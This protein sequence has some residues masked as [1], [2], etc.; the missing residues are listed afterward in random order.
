[1]KMFEISSNLEQKVN[2]FYNQNTDKAVLKEKAIENIVEDKVDIKTPIRTTDNTEKINTYCIID[3]KEGKHELVGYFRCTRN[4][5]FSK[6]CISARW[7]SEEGFIRGSVPEEFKDSV[8]NRYANTSVNA[9][10]GFGWEQ[11]TD[12]FLKMQQQHYVATDEEMQKV[13]NDDIFNDLMYNKYSE[14]RDEDIV[15][16]DN[17]VLKIDDSKFSQLVKQQCNRSYWEDLEYRDEVI[18]GAQACVQTDYEILQ[19]YNQQNKE[20]WRRQEDPSAPSINNEVV[21]PI[22]HIRSEMS[23]QSNKMRD[24]QVSNPSFEYCFKS[25]YTANTQ[26]EQCVQELHNNDDI[27]NDKLECLKKRIK[28][29]MENYSIKKRIVNLFNID[30]RKEF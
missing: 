12:I 7:W 26:Y 16:I 3:L 10:R 11:T 4:Q 1:M 21:K 19:L 30:T 17:G 2:S 6:S 5:F 24:S 23:M 20:Y 9:V 8:I 15:R 29:L 28:T 27:L 13:I 22:Q 14:S 25:Y 18:K